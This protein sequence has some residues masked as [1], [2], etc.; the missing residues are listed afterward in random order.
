MWSVAAGRSESNSSIAAVVSW[1]FCRTSAV[2][3]APTV[4]VS[5][6]LLVKF[7]ISLVT[8]TLTAWLLSFLTVTMTKS[9]RYVP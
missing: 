9:S 8:T 3:C 6:A 1:G 2:L 5:I 7:K 4:T